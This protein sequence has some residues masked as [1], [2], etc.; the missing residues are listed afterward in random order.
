ME[1][2]I[3]IEP[4]AVATDARG[5]VLEPIGP[6]A[7]PEQRNVHLV[8]T[9]PGA[10]RGNHY[11]ERGHEVT[12]VVGPALLRY[13]EAGETRDVQ[14]A[15]GQAYR[16]MIPPGIPHAFQNTGSRPIVMIGFNT[17]AHDPAGPDVVREVLIEN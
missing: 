10:I 3:T 15:A 5:I 7:L 8:L 12:V 16:V 14:F 9:E 4:I 11:H 13:R 1:P 6:D 2:R 17:V